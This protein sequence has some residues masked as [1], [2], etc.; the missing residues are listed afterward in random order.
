MIDRTPRGD[1]TEK[2]FSLFQ[3]KYSDEIEHSQVR[4]TPLIQM[5]PPSVITIQGAALLRYR[6]WRNYDE[7]RSI[8]RIYTIVYRI[9]NFCQ[10]FC[11]LQDSKQ[12]I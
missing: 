4:R 10:L 6:A 9:W 5:R 12:P 7:G 8:F 2:L 11:F 1:F 3:Y